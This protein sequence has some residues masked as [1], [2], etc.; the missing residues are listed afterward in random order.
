MEDGIFIKDKIMKIV[1]YNAY[2]TMHIKKYRELHR[3]MFCLPLSDAY[4][5]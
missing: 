1:V 4:N 5:Y 2:E 3:F